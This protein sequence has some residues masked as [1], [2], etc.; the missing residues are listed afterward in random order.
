MYRYSVDLKSKSSFLSS[1]YYR[2]PQDGD[3]GLLCCLN[4]RPNRVLVICKI[5]KN[6]NMFYLILNILGSQNKSMETL[7]LDTSLLVSFAEV[8]YA[9]A[10]VFLKSKF[11]VSATRWR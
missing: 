2:Q 7:F 8:L 4:A 5:T 6:Q 1:I 3:I 10:R 11:F 9:C